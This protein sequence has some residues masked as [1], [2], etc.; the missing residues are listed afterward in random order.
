M[1]AKKLLSIV[2]SLFLAACCLPLASVNSFADDEILT[3]ED[4]LWSYRILEDGTAEIFGDTPAY[5]GN[6]ENL[7]IPDT[8]DDITVTQLGEFSFVF[9]DCL[10][11]VVISENVRYIGPAAFAACVNLTEIIVDQNNGYFSSIGGVLYNADGTKLIAYPAGRTEST[12]TIPAGVES[13]GEGAFAYCF[14]LTDVS[15]PDGLKSIGGIA[16]A[17]CESI[18]EIVLPDSVETVEFDAFYMCTSLTSAVLSENLTALPNSVFGGCSSLTEITIPKSVTVIASEVFT[19]SALT[20]VKGY[21]D[22]EAESFAETKGFTFIS[23]D[24]IIPGDANAD[25]VTN[26]SDYATIRQYISGQTDYLTKVQRLSADLSPDSTVDAFDLFELD[27]M[28]NSI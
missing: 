18:Q 2:L 16:F 13:I 11:T 8:V 25:G 20:T 10:R 1:K 22:T 27:K 12:Y 21:Y 17:N 14:G 3:S 19:D 6:D 26:L 15:F 7:I 4:G 28:L 24:V 23:L 9:C 5:H